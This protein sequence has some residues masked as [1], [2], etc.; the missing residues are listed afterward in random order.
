[1]VFFIF[2]QGKAKAVARVEIADYT[3]E[4]SAV[5]LHATNVNGF[6][7]TL[8]GQAFRAPRQAD[9]RPANQGLTERKQKLVERAHIDVHCV[10]DGILH[11]Q[12]LFGGADI[13]PEYRRD[14]V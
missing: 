8:L 7:A 13:F 3:R 6:A 11:N 10:E 12:D 9:S 14:S 5:V 2:G 4:A 1:V